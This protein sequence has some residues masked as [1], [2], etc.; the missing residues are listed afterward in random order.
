MLESMQTH[1]ASFQLFK[2]QRNLHAWN[3]LLC[4]LSNNS[5]R[6]VNMRL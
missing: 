6:I 2:T 4:S 5:N 1:S 3:V